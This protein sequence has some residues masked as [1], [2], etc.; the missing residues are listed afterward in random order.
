[1]LD[2][3]DKINNIYYIIMDKPKDKKKVK[4]G[5]SKKK[6]KQPKTSDKKTIEALKK[7]LRLITE[8]YLNDRKTRTKDLDKFKKDSDRI[9]KKV[10]NAKSPDNI[11]KLISMLSGNKPPETIAPSQPAQSIP[12]TRGTMSERIN[13]ENLSKKYDRLLNKWNNLDYSDEKKVREFYRDFKGFGEDMADFGFDRYKYY[14][15]GYDEIKLLVGGLDSLVR[16]MYSTMSGSR[17][18]GTDPPNNP[19]PPPPPEPAPPPPPA[20]EPPAPQAQPPDPPPPPTPTPPPP[21]RTTTE[22]LQDGLSS[23][24]QPALGIGLLYGGGVAMRN[25]NRLRNNNAQLARQQDRLDNIVAPIATGLA[26]RAVGEA[27]GGLFPPTQGEPITDSLIPR[28]NRDRSGLDS[29]NDLTESI[30]DITGDIERSLSERTQRRLEREAQ[31]NLESKRVSSEM[32]KRPDL[33]GRDKETSL[34][35][36]FGEVQQDAEAVGTVRQK[37][38]RIMEED[39][40]IQAL[41]RNPDIP[42][43]GA[44]DIGASADMA[45]ALDEG[46]IPDPPMSIGDLET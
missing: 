37:N 27:V 7:Q 22:Y 41:Q 39:E 23:M 38:L 30:K 6:M 42:R 45:D 35:K 16:K 21:T 25:I 20:Q 19:A 36:E 11:A 9:K 3:Q 29:R 13:T 2:S 10:N 12:S 15:K 14:K 18:E 46:V 34:K 44:G 33:R 8:K 26:E 1:M 43:E 32:R 28:R 17:P 4:G 5:K 31:R 24:V 40:A